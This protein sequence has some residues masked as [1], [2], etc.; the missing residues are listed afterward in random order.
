[1]TQATGA[2]HHLDRPPVGRAPDLSSLRRPSPE[3]GLA[4][5]CRFSDGVLSG[6]KRNAVVVT[7]PTGSQSSASG[8]NPRRLVDPRSFMPRTTPRRSVMR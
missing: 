7:T 2:R 6:M 8:Q 3:P 1:M 5:S 4:E